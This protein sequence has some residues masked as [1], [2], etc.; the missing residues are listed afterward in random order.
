MDFDIPGELK[1]IVGL[2][3]EFARAEVR[4]A[5]VAIDRMPDPVAAFT[6]E[7]HRNITK[8]LFAL[9][10]HKLTLPEAVGGLGLAPG[11]S[12]FVIRE[13][14]YAGVGLASQMLVTPVAA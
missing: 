10:F 2:A 4:P 6:S 7:I 11:A 3:R 13:L 1:D 9:G 14:A 5:E 8:Q 12:F